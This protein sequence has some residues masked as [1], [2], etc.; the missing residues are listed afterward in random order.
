MQV[1]DVAHH[2]A[3]VFAEIQQTKRILRSQSIRTVVVGQPLPVAA[4]AIV[5]PI[6]HLSGIEERSGPDC[7]FV[8]EVV[9]GSRRLQVEINLQV[10]VKEF[11]VQVQA[12]GDPVQ[13][14]GLQ[15]TIL[16]QIADGET[17]RQVVDATGQGDRVIAHDRTLIDEILPIGIGGTQQ[18]SLGGISFVVY[19]GAE[20]VGGQHIQFIP[21]D[22]IGILGREIDFQFSSLSFFRGDKNNTVGRAVTIDSSS[23]CVFQH[24]ECFDII[25]VDHV[26]GVGRTGD[27]TL[28]IEGNSIDDDQRIVATR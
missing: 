11:G 7:T 6:N 20:F 2:I 24:G 1:R 13:I 9:L 10:V 19:N 16:I 25:G 18:C 28:L 4:E 3:L 21:N 15:N 17:I 8:G 27:A 26:Q 22:R 5:I 14:A 12:G 23:R